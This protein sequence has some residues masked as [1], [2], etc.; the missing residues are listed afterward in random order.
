MKEIILLCSFP[1]CVCVGGGG[2]YILI[3]T[4]HLQHMR[5]IFSICHTQDSYPSL[6]HIILGTRAHGAAADPASGGPSGASPRSVTARHATR[7][8][9][10]QHEPH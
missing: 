9:S 2:A 5:Q 7:R 1:L 8:R 10:R 6:F 4:R 3:R